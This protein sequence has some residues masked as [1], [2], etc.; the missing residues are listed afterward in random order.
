MEAFTEAERKKIFQKELWLL[1]N[2]EYIAPDEYTRI[3]NAHI[4]YY[5]DLAIEKQTEQVEAETDTIQTEATIETADPVKAVQVKKQVTKKRNAE[6]IRER[7]IT[8]SLNL[9][10]ILLLI[11]GLFVA[12]SNWETM[13]PWMKSGS[14]A[15]VSLL[16]YVIAYISI[17]ILRINQTGFAFMVLGSL[18]LPIFILS[19]GWFELLGRYLSFYGEGRYILGLLG[20][21]LVAPVYIVL[22][23]LLSS[24]LFV[25]FSYIGFT[26][27]TGFLLAALPLSIDAFY[28]GMIFYN[29]LLIA[30]YHWLKKT[31]KYPLFKNELIAYSQVNLVISTL[32]MLCF[33]EEPVFYGLNTIVAALLYL[34]MVYVSGRK[35]YYFVFSLM[36]VYGAYQLIENSFLDHADAI[37]YAFLGILFLF[38][39]RLLRKNQGWEKIFRM[40][41]AVTS[42]LA[43]LYMSAEGFL[44]SAGNASFVLLVAYLLIFANFLYLAAVE[45]KLFFTYLNPVFMAAALYQAELKLDEVFHFESFVLPIFM[46]GFILTVVFGYAL[47]L[48]VIKMIA[49]SSRDVGLILMF[50]ATLS[51]AGLFYWLELAIGLFMLG[52]ALLLLLKAEKRTFYTAALPWAAPVSWGLAITAL[53]E[54]W[55]QVSLFLQ[56]ELGLV[57]HFAAAGL[58]LLLISMFLKRHLLYRT[59]FY[60]A[61]AFY[62]ISLLIAL[63]S[64]VNEPWGRPLVFA[65]GVAMYF[66]LYQ[67]AARKWI[68]Y[69]LAVVSLATYFS[70]IRSLS[71]FIDFPETVD[72]A[73]LTG[74]SLALAIIA[75][76]LRIRDSSLFNGFSWVAHL[77]LPFTLLVSFLFYGEKSIVN[78]L[79]AMVI[80]SV[81]VYLVR[82]ES[83]KK[84]MLYGA[85]IAVFFAVLN[86]IHFYDRNN[87]AHFAFF[88]TSMILTIFYLKANHAFKNRTALF[89]VPFSV[90][91]L[92]S[93]LNAYPFGWFLYSTT[94]LYAAGILL[95]LHLIKWD[96]AASIPLLIVF[97]ATVRLVLEINIS[98]GHIMGLAGGAGALLTA[99]GLKLYPKLFEMNQT[100]KQL[101]S[102]TLS[103]LLFFAFSYLF[104][105]EPLLAELF[106]GVAISLALW[107]QRKR[108]PASAAWVVSF[109]AGAVLLEPYYSVMA[110]IE[111]PELFR[112]EAL[113]LPFVALA[114]YL[115]HCVEK[116]HKRLADYLQ[117]AV[118]IFVSLSLVE[119]GLA[120][121]TIYDALVLGTLSLLSMLAGMVFKVK[122]Y[123]FVGAGV[124]VLNVILQTR[125]YWGNLPWWAYLLIAGSILIAA[126]SYNEWHKQKTAKGETTFITI[127]KEKVLDRLKKWN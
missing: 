34:S 58:I 9:G 109:A 31:A 14:I 39:P 60:V 42:V 125:P 70:C 74:G 84:L 98:D 94:I 103:G 49:S 38:V 99:I 36:A 12:T 46:I 127:L 27:G 78:F 62:T 44:L 30:G 11:G 3:S 68:S 120:S 29:G 61:E 86:I 33:F 23:K 88:I 24:R 110:R 66:R 89:L 113:V 13:A 22:A 59:F 81:S 71:L 115:Q 69:L 85:F 53:A 16:F 7:N 72:I 2:K 64:T 67:V 90:V 77:F 76:A 123:F 105:A 41:S 108:I 126:A 15:L 37:F 82:S 87:E 92:L 65:G 124:L 122:S 19:L 63:G 73:L 10:V 112:R 50:L 32:L 17:R 1:K 52:L 80:Y 35:E 45:K 117:W 83:K 51:A 116:K 55:R 107:L 20:S 96:I 114:I 102:Y 8:W 121:S 93:F 100:E 111:V 28:L 104:H 26:V 47:R 57:F 75:F 106:P 118:L 119:D 79:M 95:L 5:A 40:T 43:F 21:L 56:T 18:F 91:G 25:W 54:E 6:E 101:D 48:N 4:Q 97:F